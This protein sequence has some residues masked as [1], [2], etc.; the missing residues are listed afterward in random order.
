[1]RSKSII[2]V[3]VI[4]IV[5]AAG[6]FVA[7][8]YVGGAPLRRSVALSGGPS[9][10]IST[11]LS[12][13]ANHFGSLHGSYSKDQL[14]EVQ[15]QLAEEQSMLAA[16]F[17]CQMTPMYRE[18]AQRAAQRLSTS[19]FIQNATDEKG[20]EAR[21]YIAQTAPNASVCLRFRG[22]VAIQRSSALAEH[23]GL[24]SLN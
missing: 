14:V 5:L 1:M 15:V 23:T 11:Q 2:L 3:V 17:Y 8:L 16:L 4:A 12:Y 13:M 18:L 19:P 9:G 22:T 10:I 7:G 6:C 21:T 20:R 24:A